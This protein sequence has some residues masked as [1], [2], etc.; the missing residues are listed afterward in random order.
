MA[1]ENKKRSWLI[2]AG[3]GI[4]LIAII[5]YMYYSGQ[6]ETEEE[7]ADKTPGNLPN[8]T[9]PILINGNTLVEGPKITPINNTDNTGANIN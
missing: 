1:A 3:I 5:A 8:V 2:Y 6:S 9:E 7:T 4:V